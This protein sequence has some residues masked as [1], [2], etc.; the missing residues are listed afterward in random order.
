MNHFAP[1]RVLQ[2]ALPGS[3]APHC[4]RPRLR[5]EVGAHLHLLR[6]VPADPA[7]DRNL[8][9]NHYFTASEFAQS[10]GIGLDVILGAV[11]SG[12]L[13][14]RYVDGEIVLSDA[15]VAGWMNL[16]PFATSAQ[17]EIALKALNT[18]R[19][20]IPAVE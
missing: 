5:L 13:M 17:A 3:P 8:A 14:A 15:T 12:G 7:Q 18:A 6:V 2:A 11:A 16:L 20:R 19:R 10:T 4:P 9:V 1:S